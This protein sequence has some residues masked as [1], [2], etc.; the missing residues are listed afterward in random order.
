MIHFHLCDAS[1]IYFDLYCYMY[2]IYCYLCFICDKKDELNLFWIL[3]FNALF[4][5]QRNYRMDFLNVKPDFIC[6]LRSLLTTSNVGSAFVRGF[7]ILLI[8]GAIK[9]D[10]QGSSYFSYT[11]SQC[12]LYGIY[13]STQVCG[14]YR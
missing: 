11:M 12:S 6:E 5:Y 9:I 14:L 2:F 10:K 4:L 8:Q 3:T 1:L 13:E 7:F